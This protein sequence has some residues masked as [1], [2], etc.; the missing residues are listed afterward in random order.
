MNSPDLC[1]HSNRK[2]PYSAAA[3]TSSLSKNGSIHIREGA[4]PANSVFL[5]RLKTDVDTEQLE[6]EM[7]TPTNHNKLANMF[8][9]HSV[10]DIP[11][12]YI[13]TRKGSVASSKG[14]HG[15]SSNELHSRKTRP[16]TAETPRNNK[17]EAI[18]GDLSIRPGVRSKEV[19]NQF[20]GF[21]WE[22][23]D[24]PSG[25]S[26]S[27]PSPDSPTDSTTAHR[28]YPHSHLGHGPPPSGRINA[29]KG[30]SIFKAKGPL[31]TYGTVR[32]ARSRNPPTN[33]PSMWPAA[34]SFADV[35]SEP[36]PLS[37]SLGYAMKI[38]EL[39]REDCGL[40]AWIEAVLNKNSMSPLFSPLFGC[41]IYMFP[42]SLRHDFCRT[43]TCGPDPL[44]I[45][46]WKFG[47]VRNDISYATGCLQ[48][49]RPDT[50]WS[51]NSSE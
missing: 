44:A 49:H 26:P 1:L 41:W 19:E 16:H 47:H 45:C 12:T 39:S 28:T 33:P 7:K 25:E 23:S 3:P 5:E 9:S 21:T 46:F 22:G 37:R 10:Q 38:N 36:T 50:W 13:S 51:G 32:T 4:F 15:R 29:A 18:F 42:R 6:S 34:M 48:G 30:P 8:T 20:N 31:A 2:T 24:A 40:G 35:L 14:S 11:S 27:E 17:I 43:S